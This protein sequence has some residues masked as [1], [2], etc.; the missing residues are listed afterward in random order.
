MTNRGKDPAPKP[1][2]C[3][4][5][6]ANADKERRK[7]LPLWSVSLLPTVAGH[8]ESHDGGLMRV[9]VGRADVSRHSRHFGCWDVQLAFDCLRTRSYVTLKG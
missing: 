3:N 1:H 4:T 6:Y 5:R 9:K 8:L 2:T 7:I